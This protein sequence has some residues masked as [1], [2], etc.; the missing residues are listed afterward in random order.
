MPFK[1]NRLPE[2]RVR[3]VVQER[4]KCANCCGKYTANWSAVVRVLKPKSDTKRR[5][6]KSILK[7][8]LHHDALPSVATNSSNVTNPQGN[9]QR[10]SLIVIEIS[11]IC[12]LFKKYLSFQK[13]LS[14]SYWL[15]WTWWAEWQLGQIYSREKRVQ[16][17]TD[18]A[19]PCS[20]CCLSALTVDSVWGRKG[21]GRIGRFDDFIRS[22]QN[23][24]HGSNCSTFV[25]SIFPDF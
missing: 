8:C 22:S 10:S 4:I 17:T 11:L 2:K 23:C 24:I 20:C 25:I 13:Y 18:D 5:D 14:N 7:N 1:A 9:F 21:I 15:D 6:E 3:K 19:T 16:F 12:R